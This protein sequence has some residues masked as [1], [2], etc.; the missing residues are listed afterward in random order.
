MRAPHFAML[1]IAACAGAA[2]AQVYKCPDANGKTVMQQTPCAGGQAVD[3]RPAS[4]RSMADDANR[5]HA[6][7][8]AQTEA[9]CR[10]KGIRAIRVGMSW[11]DVQCV[12]LYQYPTKINVTESAF[13]KNYQHVYRLGA[14]TEYLYF[15]N[16]YRLTLIQR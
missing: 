14:V 1:L 6:D 10:G 13:G 3:V 7:Q 15:N 16:D 11:A 8:K 2:S 5:Y 12:A 4:G 9:H